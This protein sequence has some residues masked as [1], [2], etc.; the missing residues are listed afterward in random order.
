[1]QGTQAVRGHRS[2]AHDRKRTKETLLSSG[3]S[4]TIRLTGDAEFCLTVDGESVP[5]SVRKAARRVDALPLLHADGSFAV[6]P[7][8]GHPEWAVR[9]VVDANT[10]VGG[11]R[12]KLLAPFEFRNETGTTLELR[13]DLPAELGGEAA[14]THALSG[15]GGAVSVPLIVY[16]FGQ[17]SL[18]PATIAGDNATH[19]WSLPLRTGEVSEADCFTFNNFI[20]HFLRSF[21]Q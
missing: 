8:K 4:G 21:S 7:F 14:W 6:Q 13:A 18:R 19:F 11:K 2:D 17:V 5:E 20:Y 16:A 10:E 15:N 1:M 12:V 9:Y 3:K